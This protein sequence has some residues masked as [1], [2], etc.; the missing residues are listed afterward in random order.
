MDRETM[1]QTLRARRRRLKRLRVRFA[2]AVLIAALIAVILYKEVTNQF[3]FPIPARAADYLLNTMFYRFSF[4]DL[5]DI[6]GQNG[7]PNL[8]V[9][10]LVIYWPYFLDPVLVITLVGLAWYSGRRLRMRGYEEELLDVRDLIDGLCRIVDGDRRA[11]RETLNCSYRTPA[12]FSA[13]PVAPHWYLRPALQ[14]FKPQWIDN[15]ARRIISSLTKC[16]SA[17]TAALERELDT[18]GFIEPLRHLERFY[19]L[20]EERRVS[21]THSRDRTA[22]LS[23]GSYVQNDQIGFSELL[24]FAQSL[25]PTL[26]AVAKAARH[27]PAQ[28]ISRWKTVVRKV[29]SQPLV[30]QAGMLS[31]VAGV[32][33]LIGTY[34]F[35]IRADQA[36]LTWFTVTFG[37]LTVP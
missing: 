21:K 18:A 33:M 30:K 26:V 16:D 3:L 31:C 37:S 4:R 36:F 22:F 11:R 29:F 35:K 24:L 17:L 19:F 7:A 2:V 32:V 27:K 13:L 10:L 14:W 1:V 28:R 9:P 23:R 15:A 5:A 25:T 6:L 12:F 20:V 8:F 34:F